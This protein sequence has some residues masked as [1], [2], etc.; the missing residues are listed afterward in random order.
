MKFYSHMKVNGTSISLSTS[1]R[2]LNKAGNIFV[3]PTQQSQLL[4]PLT[5]QPNS[6][7]TLLQMFLKLYGFRFLNFL[8]QNMQS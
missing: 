8:W 4:S 3:I 7:T 5:Y 6:S 1:E 2:S